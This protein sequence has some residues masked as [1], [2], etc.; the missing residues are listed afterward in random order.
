M[1]DIPDELF[2]SIDSQEVREE[3]KHKKAEECKVQGLETTRVYPRRVIKPS[4]LITSPYTE[5]KGRKRKRPTVKEPALD[6]PPIRTYSGSQEHNAK[7]MEAMQEKILDKWKIG[8]I[9]YFGTNFNLYNFWPL[10]RKI[11]IVIYLFH[12]NLSGLNNKEISYILDGDVI[13]QD[14][15]DCYA[16]LLKV[17]VGAEVG[18][19][20]FQYISVYVV[21]S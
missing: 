5:E 4:A 21:I 2:L 19:Q 6:I 17:M 9:R 8:E 3:A 10:Q 16:R 20:M 11:H 12:R 14:V 7:N 15:L 18:I 13:V 1:K